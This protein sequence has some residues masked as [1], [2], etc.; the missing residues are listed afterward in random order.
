MG[1]AETGPSQSRL[2]RLFTRLMKIEFL[3]PYVA[4]AAERLW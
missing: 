4:T 2:F 3:K 1:N